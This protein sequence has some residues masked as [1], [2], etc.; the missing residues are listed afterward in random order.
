MEKRKFRSLTLLADIVILTLSFLAMVWTKPASLRLYLP[1]HT[2]FFLALAI[3]WIIVSLI[4]GKMNRGKIVNF[5]S[6]YSRVLTSNIIAISITALAMYSLRDYV[7][8]RTIV[9]GTALLATFMELLVGSVFLAYKKAILQDPPGYDK[10]RISK[11]PS[12]YDLVNGTNGNEEKKAEHSE[13]NP[14]ISMA[15]EK[16]C[17]AE[18]AL[19]ILKMTCSNFTAR[20]SV[21]STTSIFNII[22]LAK[23]KYDYII[24]L[25]KINDIKKLDS[26]LD[27]VNAKLELK[28][29]FFC[30]VETKDQRKHRILQKYPPILNWVYYTFDSTEAKTD[31]LA[32]HVAY[33]GRECCSLACGDAWKNFKGRLPD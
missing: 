12:E 3:M 8:S 19:A 31:P 21:L 13:V 28:G 25:H 27:A 22:S 29:F 10:Y 18:M 24:N 6:L 33:Q 4:N 32:L 16:E 11:K 2:P 30:V 23:D 1:S 7:Y 5:Y 17:G 15:I 9:L 26:F 14:G 20:M